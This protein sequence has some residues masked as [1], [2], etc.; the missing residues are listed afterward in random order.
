MA[1]RRVAGTLLVLLPVV[2]GGKTLI[3]TQKYIGKGDLTMLKLNKINNAELNLKV[4]GQACGDDCIEYKVWVGK[5]NGNTPGCVW[6]E[7]AYTP[8]T[9]T[10][11]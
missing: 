1:G 7:K 6:Y 8:K 3:P 2:H 9:T 10:L 4:R 5:S 11:W